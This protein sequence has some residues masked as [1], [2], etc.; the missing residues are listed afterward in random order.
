[1]F[2]TLKSIQTAV[3][4][5]NPKNSDEAAKMFNA[6]YNISE[7]KAKKCVKNTYDAKLKAICEAK[8]K[9]RKNLDLLGDL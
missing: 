1:M 6:L 9:R 7:L 2:T 4:S 8:E 3:R 5:L